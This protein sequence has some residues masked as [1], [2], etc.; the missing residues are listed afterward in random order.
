MSSP[1]SAP[2]S[3]VTCKL[4]LWALRARYIPQLQTVQ[5]HRGHHTHSS[6]LLAH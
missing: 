2:V 4:S 3:I 5:V 6:A 1:C